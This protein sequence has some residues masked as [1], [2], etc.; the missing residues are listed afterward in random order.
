[1]TSVNLGKL[2]LGW[3][4]NEE[5][6]Y[7]RYKTVK[8]KR[9]IGSGMMGR[10]WASTRNSPVC[11]TGGATISVSEHWEEKCQWESSTLHI[12]SLSY[13]CE[14]QMDMCRMQ[15]DKKT[16]CCLPEEFW[17]VCLLCCVLRKNIINQREDRVE[18]LVKR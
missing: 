16:C 8:T 5:N 17:C 15:L 13:L 3:G 4:K 7:F 6:K 10:E 1:M 9:L 12:L 2:W 18:K 11:K 14:I